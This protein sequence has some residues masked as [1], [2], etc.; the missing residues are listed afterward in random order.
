MMRQV[1][2]LRK[3]QRLPEAYRTAEARDYIDRGY[4]DCAMG[5]LLPEIFG[6]AEDGPAVA[7]N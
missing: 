1:H 3:L 6:I 5:L 4:D 7:L 2:I